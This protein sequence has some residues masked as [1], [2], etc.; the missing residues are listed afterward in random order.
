MLKKY[1]RYA[2]L[3]AVVALMGALAVA[4]SSFA[5]AGGLGA[6]GQATLNACDA[7]SGASGFVKWDVGKL[8]VNVTIPTMKGQLA[9]LDARYVTSTGV[10]NRLKTDFRLDAGGRGVLKVEGTAVPQGEFARADII[11]GLA[12]A[13]DPFGGHVLTTAALPCV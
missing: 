1:L 11:N 12:P 13:T 10:I 8:E 5:A 9:T 6:K 7:A 2:T 3:G 4:P